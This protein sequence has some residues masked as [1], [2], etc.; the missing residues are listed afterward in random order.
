MWQEKIIMGKIVVAMRQTG[1]IT[2]CD[3]EGNTHT[4]PFVEEQWTNLISIKNVE[5]GLLYH[6]AVVHTELFS[7]L[8]QSLKQQNTARF[9]VSEIRVGEVV[10]QEKEHLFT[11]ELR[12]DRWYCANKKCPSQNYSTCSHARYVHAIIPVE[13]VRVCP[14]DS[15][16]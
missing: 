16:Q 7:R 3:V 11:V 14:Y 5:N 4:L 2:G 6:V 9:Y 1:T 12:A 10:L 13:A 8:C 15:S